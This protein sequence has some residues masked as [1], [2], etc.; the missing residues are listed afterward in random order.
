VQIVLEFPIEFN[1]KYL[2]TSIG[3][4]YRKNYRDC[5]GKYEEK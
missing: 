3:K 5:I 2:K 1:W 4:I